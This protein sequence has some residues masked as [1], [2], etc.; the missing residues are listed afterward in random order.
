[1]M[2]MLC[3]SLDINGDEVKNSFLTCVYLTC[4]SSISRL[5]LLY[6]DVLII[7]IVSLVYIYEY[8]S[9]IC[10][11]GKGSVIVSTLFSS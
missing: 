6:I 5:S 1:M 2:M 8:K 10:I 4:S 9:V 7:D 3:L 11:T